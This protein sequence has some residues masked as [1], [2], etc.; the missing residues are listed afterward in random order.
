[1]LWQLDTGKLQFLPHLSATIQNVVVSPT[2]SSYAVQLADN[3]AMVLS[4]AELKPTANISGIQLSVI[5]PEVSIESQI[6]TIEDASWTKPL[7]QR[8]PAAINPA[9]PSSLL[10]GVGQTQTIKPQKPQKMSNPYLET[11]DLGAGHNIAHQ[12]LARTNVTNVNASTMAFKMT[13]PRVTHIKISADGQ[14]LAT[15]DEWTPPVKEFEH[16]AHSA[17]VLLEEQQHRREVF[18]K[19]W[20]WNK[21]NSTWELVSRINAPHSV[22]D[23]S[24]DAGRILDIAVDPSSL[25]FST[26][27]EDGV[28]R[29]WTPKTRKRD[30]IIV[31]DQDKRPLRNWICENAVFLRKLELLDATNRLDAI[32][33]TGLLA[34]SD[35]GS[36]LAAACSS[37]DGIV[38]LVN[39]ETGAIRT[40]HFGLFETEIYG[41]QILGQD[42]IILSNHITVFDFVAQELRYGVKLHNTLSRLSIEQKQE[43]MH[44]A[45][46]EKSQTFAVSFPQ[47]SAPMSGA[48]TL[49]EASSELFVFSQDTPA[50]QYRKVFSSVISALIPIVSTQGY[51]VLDTSAEIYT[52]DKKGAMS[53][54]LAQ[55]TS[56]LQLDA[57]E[58]PSM[59]LVEV[60]DMEI[61]EDGLPTPADTQVEEDDH[62]AP[63]VSREQLSNIFDIGPAFALPP[64]EEMFNQVAGLF[65]T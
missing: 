10:V 18:L 22:G 31:R 51:L 54:Q 40:S 2:G 46:D 47:F 50:P 14:W 15:V 33:K 52:L 58:A 12:A 23:D 53:V 21:G 25:R 1:M 57:E 44:L 61:E 30:G 11:F 17:K 27:G 34:F 63:V 59:Q 60:Q 48:Q 19:F 64:M 28:V 39:P 29:S 4:T 3:S 65:T 49:W 62:E 32:P 8:V 56:A 43:M 20:Q 55:S 26:I 45:I 24:A 9:H 38:Y 5:E 42:L 37:E 36:I 41:L 35:D 6:L 7:V 16:L 13:E